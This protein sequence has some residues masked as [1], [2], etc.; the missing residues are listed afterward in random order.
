MRSFHALASLLLSSLAL[1]CGPSYAGDGYSGRLT[2][3]GSST[4]APLLVDVAKRFEA[5]H[6]GLRIDVQTGGS[7]RGI[8]D[9]HAGL[10]DIGMSSRY[11]VGPERDALH[12]HRIAIDGVAFVLNGAN[13]VLRLSREQLRGIFTGVLDDWSQVGG[14]A[15]PITVIDRARGRSEVSLITGYLEFDARDIVPDAV[16]GENQ[17]VVK[18]VASDP[19]AISYLSVGTALVARDAG[20]SLRLLPLA[21]VEANASSVQA[22]VYPLA[23]PLLLL[24]GGDADERA[25]AF[26]EFAASPAIHDL[27]RDHSFVPAS[28]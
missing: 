20:V 18:Q 5:S 25:R 13:P 22:R 9:V 10:A 8:A 6:P 28:H 23:R 7:S 11:L 17:Q 27:I 3:T 26:V 16:A 14:T 2:V 1:A 21:D 12:E 24:L 4:I 15:G 19:A